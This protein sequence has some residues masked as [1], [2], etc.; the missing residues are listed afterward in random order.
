MPRRKLALFNPILN[1]RL[2]LQQPNRVRHCCA[3]LAR[4]LCHGFLRKVKFIHQ[5]FECPR[6]LDR[7]QVFALDVFH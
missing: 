6:C 3:V 2:Q 5:A 1:R 7:V 4:S